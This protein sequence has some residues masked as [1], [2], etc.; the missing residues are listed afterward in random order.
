MKHF[1]IAIAFIFSHV[2][3]QHLALGVDKCQTFVD[4]CGLHGYAVN[5]PPTFGSG[6]SVS[7]AIATVKAQVA[8]AFHQASA[9]EGS[10]HALHTL[11]ADNDITTA[12][13]QGKAT[14]LA[15][16]NVGV[17]IAEA[18]EQHI[19]QFLIASKSHRLKA[20]RDIR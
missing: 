20:I 6:T 5:S 3:G 7:A 1:L 16:A 13:L 8:S 2:G 19:A 14:Q 15:G 9:T 4:T 10:Q 12:A 11:A 18:A 17:T